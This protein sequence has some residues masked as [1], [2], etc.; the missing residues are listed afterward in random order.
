M[1]KHL[2]RN[3]FACVILLLCTTS[4]CVVDWYHDIVYGDAPLP[5]DP[6]APAT[7]NGPANAPVYSCNEIVTLATDSL[8]F[9]F[10]A[11]G[12]RQPR[13][14]YSTPLLDDLEINS[15][16]FRI[17]ND[18][19]KNKVI[20]PSRENPEYML[21]FTRIGKDV[22][23]VSVATHKKS[24]DFSNTVFTEQYKIKGAK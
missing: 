20:I 21:I 12:I 18:L 2:F 10:T 9:F 3:I 16:G 14:V 19:A 1:L 15:S 4:C 5:T 8:I 22:F 6:I 11:N 13:T 24:G 7:G 17:F 23:Q